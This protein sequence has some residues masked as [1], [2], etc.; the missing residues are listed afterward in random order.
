MSNFFEGFALKC[1]TC[2][3]DSDSHNGECLKKPPEISG[4]SFQPKGY[5]ESE[6][7]YANA[8]VTK[9]TSKSY[10]IHICKSKAKYFIYI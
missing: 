10:S 9:V 3:K 4:S 1:W 6:C 7:T 8:C 5:R 2:H